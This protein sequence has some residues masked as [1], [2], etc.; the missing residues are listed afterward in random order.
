MKLLTSVLFLVSFVFINAQTNTNSFEKY[1]V[2]P[3]C[4]TKEINELENCFNKTLQEF[5]YKNFNTPEIVSEENYNGNVSVFFEVDKEGVFNILYVDGVYTELKDEARRVF[6]Q[7]PT[8]TPATY[9]G[10][11]AY[12]QFTFTIAIPLQEPV[13]NTVKEGVSKNN[14]TTREE[15]TSLKQEYDEITNLAYEN[16]EYT[17]VI[18]I[19]LSHHN[20]SLF[21][22]ALNR[23]GQNNHT[24]QKPFIYSEVNKYYN[25]EAENAK[26]LKN[27]ESWFGRKFWDE[28]M[29][30]IKGE[31][32]WITLDPGVDLQVGKD[33]DQEIDTYNNTRL[34]Y[35]QG[36]LGKNFNFFA[37]VRESQG[38][39]AD[40]FN[41]FAEARKPDGGN[42]AIIPGQG[43]A[44]DFRTD[45]YDYP[46]AEGHISYSP[47]KWINIQLGHGKNFIG[48]GYRS[49]LLSDNASPYPFFKLNTTF[50]KLKYTN[51]WMSLRD[52]RPEVTADGSF[53]TKYVASHYLS[54]NVTK[55]LNLGFF[56]SV[57]WQNDNDRGFDFNYLNPVIFYRAIEFSTGSRGG[58]ALIG[59]SAKYKFTDRVNAYAQLMIDEFSSGDI[60]GGEGSFKNKIAHQIGVKYYDAFGVQGLF[61]QGEYNRVRPYTYSHNTIV[62]NYGHNNQS[63]A[64]TLGA[65][66]Y[67]FVGV[68]RYQNG[69]IFGDAKVVYAKR[70]FEFNTTE[71]SFY[72]G[73]SI[74]G[75][76]DNR[77]SDLGNEITQ[78]NT[79]DFFHTE[80]LGGY[81]LNPATNLKVYGSVIFRNFSP[82]ENTQDVFKNNTTW[83]NFG[84]RTDLFNWYYD[85]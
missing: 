22:P 39:F 68:A 72:Y 60:F 53:R 33:F 50:W 17:S 66:F 51:T 40:Y 24:A 1:P 15:I 46:I 62:L 32:Y 35:A 11:P 71:D 27:K 84:I 81:L 76:E 13:N 78:G 36:G 18:N 65:N 19:P 82:N 9:N 8:I 63:L 45:S 64:H 20:Y 56:E 48:D 10:N 80:I 5:I 34:V 26:L 73:S 2:F 7:L 6:E 47:S 75:T 55:R 28:H 14:I 42:P 16:E 29:V 23:V 59:L 83:V 21:D 44:K 3:E 58:N 12:V 38:R 43:I 49:L 4:E 25:F 74:Y 69:R 79:T 52:V 85:F 54:Y 30:T 37:V 41:R 70:G 31:D 61:L 77:I 67:E 57:I